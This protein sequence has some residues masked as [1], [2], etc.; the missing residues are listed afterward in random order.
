MWLGKGSGNPVSVSLYAP[1][2]TWPGG[3]AVNFD[4]VRD[5]RTPSEMA[6]LVALLREVPG[7]APYLEGLEDKNWG[8]HGEVWNLRRSS[9][10]EEALDAFTQAI[11][12]AAE[13]RPV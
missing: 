12:E 9:A 1:T 2:T 3:V 11:I 4:F 10:S 6:R 8:M 13:P 7:V 5:K